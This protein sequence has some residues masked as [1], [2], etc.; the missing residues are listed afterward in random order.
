M[1]KK[2]VVD[3]ADQAFRNAMDWIMLRKTTNGISY[4]VIEKNI[5][6]IKD[7]SMGRTFIM[8]LLNDIKFIRKAMMDEIGEETTHKIFEAAE[9]IK[10]SGIPITGVP[11]YDDDSFDPLEEYYKKVKEEEE[12]DE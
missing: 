4:D 11:G 3:P 10:R 1:S 7:E 9:A 6:G 8:A 2:K 5:Y 12:E